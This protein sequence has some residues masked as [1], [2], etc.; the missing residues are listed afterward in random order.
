M[1]AKPAVPPVTVEV[2]TPAGMVKQVRQVAVR[3]TGEVVP[4]GDL[5]L[6]DPFTVD[7]AQPGKGRWVDSRNW[8][9]DFERD[10]P[11]GVACRF[12]LKPGQHA[13]SGAALGGQTVYAFT[14]GGPAVVQQIPREGGQIDENQVFLFG[15][16]APAT[17]DSIRKHAWCRI[18]GVGEKVGVR[19]LQGKERDDFLAH[20]QSFV[21]RYL[22][23]WWKAR[24]VVF[25]TVTP[26]AAPKR[27]EMPFAVLQCQRTLPADKDVAIVWDAGI[28]TA[29]GIA[30]TEAQTLPY[31]VRPDF[32][33]MFRCQRATTKG[34]CIPFLPMSLSF[35]AP[36]KRTDL[37][38]IRLTAPDGKTFA[39]M[40]SGE[41]AKAEYVSELEFRGPFPVK[42]ALKLTLPEGLRDDAGRALVNRAALPAS[43]RT[44]DN[45]PLVKFPA[46][47]GILEAKGDRLLPVTV[48]NVETRLRASVQRTPQDLPAAPAAPPNT[49]ATAASTP[50]AQSSA[51]P[52][53]RTGTAAP[54]TPAQVLRVPAQDDAAIIGWLRRMAGSSYEYWEPREQWGKDL[55]TPLIGKKDRAERIAIP[56]GRGKSEFEVIGIPLRRPGFYVVEVAS[57]LLGAGLNDAPRTANVSASALVTNMAAHFKHG[58]ASS[59]VWVTSLDQGRPVSG[60]AVTVR[61]CDGKQLWQGRTD[62]NGVARIG[63]EITARCKQQGERYFISARK[64]EDMTFTLSDWQGGIESW[65]F[66]VLTGDR[67]QDN[68]IATTVFDRTLLRA[69]ETVHMKHFLR[70][71]TMRGIELLDPKAKRQGSTGNWH[72]R[73]LKIAD[74]SARPAQIHIVHSAT[75]ERVALPVKWTANAT[76]ESSWAI[77]ADAKLG[78]YEVFIGG[79]SAGSFRVEQFR[80]PTMRGSIQGPKEAQ[81]APAAVPL[82]LQLSYLSGGGA[83]L[84]AVKLRTVLE[85]REVSF[86][87]QEGFR[88]SRGDVKEGV[89]QNRGYNGDDECCDEDSGDD[90]GQ[91]GD[92]AR[93][94]DGVSTRPVTLDKAGGARVTVDKFGTVDA[95]KDLLAE[96]SYQD[97]NGETLTVS[98]RVPLWPAGVIVGIKPD[99]WMA[100]KDSVKLQAIALDVQGKPLVH[101]RIAV[102]FFERATY[103]HRRRLLGGFYSYENSSEIKR[104]GEACAGETDERGLLFCDVKAPKDGELILRAQATD[105]AGRINSTY[106]DVW[107]AGNADLWFSHSDNDRIDLL[108]LKKRYEPGEQAS[109]QVRMPFRS[110]TALVTVEREGVIETYVRRISG[111]NPVITIPMKASY[112]PNVYVSALVVRGRVA[113]VQPTALVDLGKPAYKMGIATVRVGWAAHELKVQVTPDKPVYKI[114]EKVP[115]AVH[116]TRAD[117]KALPAG[118]EVALAAVDEGLLE[119]MPNESW[120]LLETMMQQ[121]TLQVETSTAQM[122]VIGKRHFGR[123]AFPH[124]GGGGRSS[125]R[126]LFDTLLFWKARVVLD[127]NG[128]AQVTV[129]LNDSLTSFRIVAIASGGASLFGSGGASVRTTQDVMMLAGLPPLVR[130]GDRFRA[131]YTVRNA[132]DRELSVELRASVAADLGKAAAL[133]VQTVTLAAGESRDIGWDYTVPYNVGTLAWEATARGGDNADTVKIKQTVKPALPVRTLQATLLQLDRPQT[134]KVQVPADAVPG[135]GGIVTR[136]SARIA[137]EMPGVREY[138]KD[139]PYSCFEQVTSKAVA[140]RDEEMWDANMASLPAYLDGDG[141]VKYFTPMLYGSDTLTAYVLS[142]ADEAGYGIPDELRTRMEEG[143]AGFVR[144]KVIRYSAM[145]TADVAVRK[146][147]ALEALSRRGLVQPDM[148]ES[149]TIAPNL[150]PTAAVID[151]YL[152]LQRTPAL[153]DQQK[154]L[155]QTASILR[156]RLNL[157]GTTMGFSTERTDNWWWLM[158]SGDANANRLLLAM[159]DNPAWQADMGRLARGAIGRQRKG[160]WNTTVAN[161]WGVL[162]MEKFSEKFE[163]TPVTGQSLATL[164]GKQKAVRWTESAAPADLVATLPWPNVAQDLTLS[165][166]GTG[167]PWVVV[168]STA[169]IPLKA[170]LTTGFRATRTI[171]PVEQ[172]QAGVW[173]RGDIY[174]VHLDLESQA[175]MTWVV[176]DD[177]IPAGASTLGGGLGRDSAIATTGERQRGWVWPAF[178]ERK[179]DAFRSYYEFVPKGKWSVE[180]TVRLNNPGQFQLPPTRIEAMYNPE[181]FGEYPNAPFTVKP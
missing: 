158:M 126:E 136:F 96:M 27:S 66:N 93:G 58:A 116:V 59:V 91:E 108:P 12:T 5:R 145:P 139:Y 166:A 97:P 142:V 148:T 88:F 127:K 129:P 178:Q 128:D 67:H 99:A 146:V 32:T 170:P 74:S 39:P 11:A 149:F 157:Q 8:S 121:R 177:P 31:H 20:R 106:A 22:H 63:K 4:F 2:F 86:P 6:D 105:S 79:L 122:Q 173:S 98:Q 133:P 135:R 156:A 50:P 161:A 43:V 118:S 153:P 51:Q 104:L 14:T 132:S 15:L 57:P 150:W 131:G 160:K 53:D 174:R 175:D 124:G 167:K 95:P 120:N 69:G 130:E 25:H 141:L 84:A 47:F 9:Y 138:M 165:H 179:F 143:L 113:G 144:G 56:R 134:M 7:C 159:L 26:G 181:M 81:I 40:F 117:G 169:A 112:A 100:T 164:A 16:D 147:A 62:A 102:D 28:A 71:H 17:E 82:D 33:A 172:K 23:V 163:S 24:G 90:E 137:D 123:K 92:S 68:T 107:V 171:T 70:E 110:A 140:L 34:Q 52:G 30:T 60:A 49:T 180:Y 41:E 72:A 1:S 114:R 162:A 36:V 64:G 154:Q 13:V 103:S 87:D 115:V 168:Q 48:R 61:D 77:P 155:Q 54:S 85:P 37:Q 29:S 176:V 21:D 35:S 94:K 18:D 78:S 109:F 73:A 55:D 65:R 45:P 19:L 152:V 75:D 83:G 38:G 10:L 111:Q 46:R 125:G 76:S 80:I 119:L 101:A 42:S 3:F 151:W 44:D 89:E